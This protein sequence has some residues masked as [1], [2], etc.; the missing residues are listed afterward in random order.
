MKV[1][2]V[3]T[4]E[5]KTCAPHSDLAAAAWMMWENDCGPIPVV[6]PN[7]ALV[8]M[9]TDRDICISVATKNRLASDIKVG[10]TMS[11][12]LKACSQDDNVERALEIMRDAQVRRLPVT[13][14]NQRLQ[15]IVSINDLIRSAGGKGSELPSESVIETLKAICEPRHKE[16]PAEARRPV[17]TRG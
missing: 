4:R 6:D 9:I 7:G 12:N 17:G 2:D 10:E 8:G 11:K 3:M 16:E 14:S 15:G 13:D 1:R 5:V